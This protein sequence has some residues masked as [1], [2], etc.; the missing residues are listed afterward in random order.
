MK[1]F[2]YLVFFV[3]ITLNFGIIIYCFEYLIYDKESPFSKISKGEK[4]L[5][6]K[7]H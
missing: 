6:K 7:K 5:F 3:L 1:N 4:I 2:H